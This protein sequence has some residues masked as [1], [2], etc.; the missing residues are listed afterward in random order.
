MS[1]LTADNSTSGKL[2]KRFAAYVSLTWEMVRSSLLSAME[3]RVSFLIQV[4]GM[5]VNDIALI[6]VWVIFFQ[7]FPSIGGWGFQDTVL[8]FAL[9]TVSFSLVMI[10]GAGIVQLAKTIVRGELD[11]YLSFPKNVLWHVSTSKTDV[12]AVGDLIFGIIIF[13]F[14]GAI[15]LEKA[16]LFLCMAVLSGIIFFNCIVI[17]Q[18][19]AFFVGNFEDAADHFFDAL[20]GFSIYPQ[21]AFYGALK[22]VMLTI[23]P[24]F[25]MVTLPIQLIR[26]FDLV[27]FLILVLFTILSSAAAVTIFSRG[28]RKYE[29]GN[30]INV[31]M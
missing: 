24:A 18:S 3:Y 23:V 17:S 19:L 27:F 8:L 14:S 11:Y 29:S 20:L 28:L 9:S 6:G 25:F 13:F 10:F 12:S 21:T 7:R 1:H 26:H 4:V 31:K 16:G 30:L 15:S 5:I 22:V 2:L